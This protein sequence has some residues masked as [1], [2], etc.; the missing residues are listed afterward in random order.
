SAPTRAPRFA[1]HAARPSHASGD[2][3]VRPSPRPSRYAS[4]GKPTAKATP[5]AHSDTCAATN[6]AAPHTPPPPQDPPH[7]ALECPA[8]APATVK[9]TPEARAL[10]GLFRLYRDE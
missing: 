8:N 2:A 9:P 1:P 7:V 10:P 4:P 6:G 5:A 3:A